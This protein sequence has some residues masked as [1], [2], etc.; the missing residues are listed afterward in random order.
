MKLKLEIGGEHHTL[1][2]AADFTPT[3]ESAKKVVGEIKSF[4][5]DNLVKFEKETKKEEEGDD[6]D[7]PDSEK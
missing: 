4:I 3:I 7:I 6:K 2:Y 1:T 5:E